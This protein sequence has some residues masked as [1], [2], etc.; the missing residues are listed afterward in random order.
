MPDEAGSESAACRDWAA[1]A[2]FGQIRPPYGLDVW[3]AL[4]ILPGGITLRFD[5]L[6]SRRLR[7]E[8]RGAARSPR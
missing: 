7:L 3:N 5:G 2:W 4:A 8:G 1:L 6:K